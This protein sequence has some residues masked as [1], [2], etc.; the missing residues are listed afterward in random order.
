MQYVLSRYRL[1]QNSKKMV[2][3]LTIDKLDLA[4]YLSGGQPNQNTVRTQDCTAHF[5][6]TGQPKHVR[7]SCFLFSIKESDEICSGVAHHRSP[8]NKLYL[9]VRWAQRRRPLHNAITLKITWPT[10]MHRRSTQKLLT[11]FT[12]QLWKSQVF[13]C[14]LRR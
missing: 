11:W 5:T 14:D 3:I 12:R 6:T 2:N 9:F 8:C 10:I 1:Q 4:I 7:H 13:F